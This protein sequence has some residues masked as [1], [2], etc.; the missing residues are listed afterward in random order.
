MEV[1]LRVSLLKVEKSE[2][3]MRAS[4]DLLYSL[5]VFRG[6][7]EWPGPVVGVTLSYISEW[8]KK[9]CENPTV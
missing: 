4:V 1:R 7:K 5:S 6:L 8:T 2:G 3:P 9:K